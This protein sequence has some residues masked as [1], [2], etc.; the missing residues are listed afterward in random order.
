MSDP[1]EPPETND[2]KQQNHEDWYEKSE[3]YGRGTFLG[4]PKTSQ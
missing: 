2:S 1:Q 4:D 3:L